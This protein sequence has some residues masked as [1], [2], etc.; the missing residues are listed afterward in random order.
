MTRLGIFNFV[1][2]ENE[3]EN[4]KEEKVKNK[5]EENVANKDKSGFGFHKPQADMVNILF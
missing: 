4:E 3:E 2:N 1:K 5:E